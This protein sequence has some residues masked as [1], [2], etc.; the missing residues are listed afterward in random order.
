MIQE[1]SA[2][3]KTLQLKQSCASELKTVG[4][5]ISP[6]RKHSKAIHKTAGYNIAGLPNLEKR[7]AKKECVL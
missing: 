6:A 2:T 5:K 1:N 4:G 3:Y 7:L